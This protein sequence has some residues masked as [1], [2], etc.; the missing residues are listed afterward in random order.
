MDRLHSVVPDQWTF[1]YIPDTR[2]GAISAGRAEVIVHATGP[3]RSLSDIQALLDRADLPE[4][5]KARAE[6][7]F[8]LLAEAEATVHGTSID[9]IHFHEVGALDAIVDVV[10]CCLAL[11]Q[12]AIDRIVCSPLVTG[13]GYAESAHGEIPIP[14]PA[15][16]EI[17]RRKGIPL[18]G[19]GE[20][21]TVT[22]TGIALVGALADEFGHLPEMVVR[23]VGYGAGRRNEAGVP[24]VVRAVVGDA[25]TDASGG[26]ARLI[27]ANIDDAT[28]ELLAHVVE[29]LLE[30][31][32]QDAWLTPIVMKKGRVAHLLSVLGAAGDIDALADLVFQETTTFGVRISAVEKRALERE[33]I[34]VELEGRALRVKLAR[35]GGRIVTMSPEYEDAAAVAAVTGL[36]LK[37]VYARALEIA[38]TRYSVA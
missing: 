2:R 5:V 18:Q 29:R 23:A 19:R 27:E 3:Q 4:T 37:E 17:A 13:R 32:A 6:R 28:P 14:G 38:R 25:L 26:A 34:T 9:E 22:P 12:L 1:S 16:I 10:G 24:N 36:P 31:G 35:L 30:R 21:E 8:R 20:R 11:D 15:V 7:V 33:W